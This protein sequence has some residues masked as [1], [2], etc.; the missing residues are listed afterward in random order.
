[1]VCVVYNLQFFQTTHYHNNA[2]ITIAEWMVASSKTQSRLKQKILTCSGIN[3][4]PFSK[5]KK[6]AFYEFLG[7]LDELRMLALVISGLNQARIYTEDYV[8]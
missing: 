8:V 2:N 3:A 6:A 1:M 4:V 7:V 5:L